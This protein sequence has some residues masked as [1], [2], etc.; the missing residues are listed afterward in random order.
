MAKRKPLVNLKKGEMENGFSIHVLQERP[1][2][3]SRLYGIETQALNQAVL[4]NAERFPA[5]FVF[6]LTRDEITRISQFVISS[7]LLP[8]ILDKADQG[9]L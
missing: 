4:Q 9:E 3:M 7:A 1:S 6:K 2:Q 8:S 5:D